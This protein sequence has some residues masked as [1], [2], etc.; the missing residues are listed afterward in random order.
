MGQN[1]VV[2][3]EEPR[4]T[5]PPPA[6]SKG[7]RVRNQPVSP[8]G[9][10]DTAALRRTAPDRSPAVGFAGCGNE[11]AGQQGSWFRWSELVLITYF[12]YAAVIALLWPIPRAV[13]T[14]TLGL[15]LTIVGT[16]FSLAYA[17][18]LRPAWWALPVLRDWLALALVVL[19]YREM[20]WFAPEQ[21]TFELENSWVVWDRLLL[22]DW[23][24]RSV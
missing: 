8:S 24:H 12:L 22:D 1:G 14:L 6:A 23:G 10:L 18:R 7:D 17:T 9:P 16:L 15:N 19:C 13:S 20:G 3:T 21:H 2:Q 4:Q 11:P 5:A